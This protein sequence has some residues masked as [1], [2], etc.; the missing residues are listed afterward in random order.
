MAATESFN[1][2]NLT[3]GKL[4][5]D[6]DSLYQIPEYQRPYKW[7]DDQVDQL[8]LDL[9]ESFENEEENYFLGSII[10]SKPAKAGSY[11]DVV[12]GQQRLTTLIILLAVVRDMY[13]LINEKECMEDP[14]AVGL[15]KIKNAIQQSENFGRLRVFTHVNHRT[16]FDN[17][18]VNG[19]TLELKKPAKKD[20][21]RDEEPKYKFQNTACIFRAYLEEM[22]VKQC[23]EFIN[24]LFNRVR[25]IRIDCTNPGF[26]IKLF[27]VLNARGLDLSNSDLIKSFLIAKLRNDNS[28]D[29]ET[30]QH[31]EDQFMQNWR[32][33][34][35]IATSVH[36]GL[37]DLFVMYEYY[38]LGTNPKKSLYE[39]LTKLFENRKPL[40]VIGDFKKF[41]THYQVNVYDIEDTVTY[42][43]F[44]HSNNR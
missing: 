37:N 39:E 1:P 28:E 42:S 34:E 2:T 11:L 31:R 43:M 40:E 15:G 21:K 23:G 14:A 41:C 9:K 3:V 17:I 24:Y 16:D 32:E 7:T 10:T 6:S 35:A 27:Q 5:T 22:D 38:L 13:P 29:P 8:W 20:V 18:I 25:I 4:L 26:A 30:L 33:V 19:N 36:E 12:D 44:Y